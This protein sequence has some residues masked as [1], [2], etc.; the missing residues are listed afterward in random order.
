[1]FRTFSRISIGARGAPDE[2]EDLADQSGCV[3]ADALHAASLR[4]VGT[5]ESRRDQVDLRKRANVADVLG[6]GHLREV[7]SENSMGGVPPLAEELS[8]A[9]A[10]AQAQLDPT[11]PSEES[12]N[13][14]ALP[15]RSRRPNYTRGIPHRSDPSRLRPDR[16]AVPQ[17]IRVSDVWWPWLSP[18]AIR[19]RSGKT[20]TP[21]PEGPTALAIGGSRCGASRSRSPYPDGR[22]GD[23]PQT[24]RPWAA[25]RRSHSRASCRRAGCSSTRAGG[26]HRSNSSS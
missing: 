12:G 21:R 24:S 22:R 16:T 3:P 25:A 17:S 8:L 9:A 11:Y 19:V 18:C 2:P 14:E 5:G 10:S 20:A 26:K 23:R 6:E 1:M 15:R 7:V 4:E 13:T